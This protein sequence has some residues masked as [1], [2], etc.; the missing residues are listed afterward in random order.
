VSKTKGQIDYLL[1]L[2]ILCL[3]LFGIIMIASIGVP[4]SIE[5]SNTARIPFPTCGQDGIDCYFLLKRHISRV[6]IG[7]F[8]FWGAIKIPINFWRRLAPFAFIATF[9]ILI[10]VLVSGTAY[11]TFATGWLVVRGTSLQ[12][13]EFAKIGL[14][15]YLARWLENKGKDVEDFHKGFISFSIISG[16]II[17]PLVLQPD[18]GAAMTFGMIAVGM[19]YL[20]GAKIKHLAVGAVVATLLLLVAVSSQ[21]YLKYRVLAYLNP[22]EANCLINETGTARDYCWQTDQANIAVASGGF[23]GRGLT[24]GVQKAYWLPQSHDDFIFAASAEELGFLRSMLVVLAFGFIG[25]RGLVI[26]KNAPDRFSM[27]LATG[28]TLWISGQAFINI[29]V[30]TGVL[31]VTGLTLPFISY[32]G[33]SILASLIGGGILLNISRYSNFTYASTFNRGRDSRSRNAKYSPYR[34]SKESESDDQ[35]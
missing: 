12:P 11:T 4:K 16:I 18:F 25:Y 21:D 33:S 14:I 10:F 1:A 22:S 5:L 29:G 19:F 15:I 13:S 6:I 35:D 31:P 8:F 7:L 9:L 23:F 32:G 3:V 20:A 30:N 28:I 34:M 27:F 26:A 24:K 2:V 17:L